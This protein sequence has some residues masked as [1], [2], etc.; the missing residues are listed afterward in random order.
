M[1]QE[2]KIAGEWAKK[3]MNTKWVDGEPFLSYIQQVAERT[4]EECEKV[5][6]RELGGIVATHPWMRLPDFKKD[7]RWWEEEA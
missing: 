2:E 6:L 1:T 5:M 7:A 3:V 4:L